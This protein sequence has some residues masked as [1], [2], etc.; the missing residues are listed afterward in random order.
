[1]AP[2]QMDPPA[3]SLSD[4]SVDVLITSR[5]STFTKR[6]AS[7][8]ERVRAAKMRGRGQDG[9]KAG[10]GGGTSNETTA[11]GAP[12]SS[13]P[14]SAIHHC[15]GS[16]DS[17]KASVERD[18]AI[19]IGVGRKPDHKL[20]RCKR[21]SCMLTAL[22]AVFVV[23][24][25]VA[26][27]TSLIVIL[28][29]RQPDDA[30]APPASL[31][32]PPSALPSASP[33]APL[34]APPHLDSRQ[35]QPRS[36]PLPNLPPFSPLPIGTSVVSAVADVVTMQ[37][38]L[39]IEIDAFHGAAQSSMRSDLEELLDCHAPTCLLDLRVAAGSVQVEVTA[40]IPKRFARVGEEIEAGAPPSDT[41][42]QVSS[43]ASRLLLRPLSVSSP[44]HSM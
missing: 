20:G 38:E 3:A 24:A 36:P 17:E 29:A 43:L 18:R 37:L 10:R 15:C 2:S 39:S 16:I 44:Q 12:P 19:H 27:A 33:S 42:A 40:T 7:R 35:P 9:S 31:A 30:D 11:S 23:G 5:V 13:P 14:A 26:F 1:M 34:P 25:A 8:I 21:T 32:A 28:R 6:V 4:L 41:T 22:V